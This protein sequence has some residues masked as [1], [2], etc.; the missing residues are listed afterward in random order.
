MPNINSEYHPP[1]LYRN[2]HVNTIFANRIRPQKEA[3]YVRKR[4]ESVDGDFYDVDTVLGGH[5]TA[6]VLMHGLEG[7]AQSTYILEMANHF[8]NQFDVWAM[9]HRSCSGTPNRLYSSYHSGHTKD[10]NALIQHLDEKYDHIILLGVSLGGNITLL[11]VGRSADQLST[12]I[13]A[14]V[15]ISVPVQLN[16]AAKVLQKSKNMVYL[17]DFLVSLKGK[18]IPKL[19]KYNKSQELIDKISKAKTFVEFDS[20]YTGPAHGFKDAEDYWTQCSSEQYL[21]D[22]SIPTLLLN[23]KDDPFLSEECYPYEKAARN[24]CLFLETP[25]YGGHVG[26]LTSF[27]DKR[28]Y[29]SRVDEF[30]REHLKN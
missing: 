11:H 29:L 12:K 6:I 4:F 7:S 16:S 5:T 23:A 20:L 8:E 15:G 18:V 14:V 25:K 2:K 21:Q 26:F 3:S 13:R 27:N 30:L 22:I 9:N 28:W 24:E 10:L 19:E 1:F 17:Q